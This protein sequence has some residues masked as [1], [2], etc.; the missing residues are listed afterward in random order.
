MS[1]EVAQ[2]APDFELPSTRGRI[3]LRNLIQNGPVL[4]VF[5]P[6]D[7]TP[8]CTKQLCDYRDNLGKFSTLQVQ[9]LG[10]NPQS[11]ESHEAFAKKYDLPFPLV[12]DSS[13]ETCRAYDALGL[14]GITQRK[15][16]L[17]GR[18]GTIKYVKT[19]WPVFRRT[20]EELEQVLGSLE[21]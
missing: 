1:T 14:L 3:R 8:V 5:Y 13:K 2:L 10:I 16:V 12:S 6:G 20:A 9:V 17:V 11:V 7:D 15:L 19:D 18:D 4:L 21:L